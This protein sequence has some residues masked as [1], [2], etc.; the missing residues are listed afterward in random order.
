VLRITDGSR[1]FLFTGDIQERA[2]RELV[3]DAGTLTSDFL[4]VPHHGSKTSSTERFLE[5]VAPRVA[6]VSVGEANAFGQPADS[7]LERYAK[8]GVR[9]LRT[10]MDGEVSARTDGTN[11]EI[12]TYAGAKTGG[13]DSVRGEKFSQR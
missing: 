4:K 7:V 12:A 9:L 1:R 6:V 8:D 3:R 10:D 2:E 13:S 11:L 5:A